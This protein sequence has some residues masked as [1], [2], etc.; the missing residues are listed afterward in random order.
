MEEAF[1]NSLEIIGILFIVYL[2]GYSTFLFVSVIIGSSVLY[3]NRQNKEFKNQLIEE[4]FVPVTIIVPAY[5]EEIT[6]VD[7]VLSLLELDYKLYEIIVVDDGSSDNTSKNLIDYFNLEKTSK[8]IRKQIFCQV[9][10]KIYETGSQ[11]VKIT[12]IR[13]KNGGKADALN[14][15]I[16]AAEFPYFICMDADSV[17]QFDSLQKIISPVMEFENVIAV[18]GIVKISNGVVFNKGKVIKYCLPK[19]I[20]PC[21]QALEYD[22]SFLA[23]RIFFDKFNANLIISGAFGMFKKD[24]VIAVGGYDH[25]TMGEDMELVV[26]LHLFCKIHKTPYNIKYNPDAVCWSQSPYKLNDLIKQRRRWHLGLFQSMWT[27]RQIFANPK[28]GSI[29]FISFLY[30]LIY[31]LLS[32]FIEIFGVATIIIS[33]YLNLINVAFGI[34]FFALYTIFGVVLSLTIF[35]SRIYTQDLKLSVKDII[36]SI[37]LCFLEISFLRFILVFVRAT[38]FFGYKK[39]K[40]KWGKIQRSKI[41]LE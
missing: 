41:D 10:E 13:K 7:T 38:A 9:E 39:R 22:R 19:Q 4:F 6:V 20:L 40:M 23:S 26:K 15:G 32:P 29:S 25:N 11:K 21:M 16:N 37:L 1:K 17:L 35:F 2:M 30:Y 5:N 27:H 14:M 33:V 12:L 34:T 31:E 28:Y 8:P 3:K 36:K 24:V 18:G